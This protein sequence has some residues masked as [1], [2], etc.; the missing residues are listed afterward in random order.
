MKFPRT[1]IE[2]Q[3][4]F[5]SEASCWE[6]LREVRWPGGFRCPRCDCRG[7]SLISTRGLEQ[8]R[9]CRYQASV[10]AGTVFHKTRTP[11]RIWFL[12]VFFVAR[13]KKGI[14]AL[15]FQKDAGIGSYQ[16]AWTMLHKLRSAL[17]RRAGELLSGLV[18][19]DEAY[20][21]GPRPG[22]RGR[23]AANKSIVAV[24]VE[25]RAHSAG[26][27]HLDVIPDVSFDSLGPFV[28]GAIEGRNA[29]VLTDDWHG[30]WPLA[31]N[32]VDHVS[33]KLGSGPRA[34]E[35][36]PWVHKVI[37][38]LKTWLRGTFHGVSHKHLA[39]YLGE[40]RYRL[41][42]RWHEE[43]L[44]PAVLLRAVQGEPLPY[45]R[46]TAELVG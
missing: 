20:V 45:H 15:Q 14:S 37:S 38:N 22:S 11:L 43:D 41:N 9:S 8:C 39:R 31:R 27:A 13:H 18:E 21:G 7:S 42:G 23:H 46:L 16:T 6:Y 24:A 44:F 19:A 2:F 32:G 1:L 29:T 30:Y 4:Q 26:T 10:T 34:G 17:G 40:Y 33:T 5:P 36:L 28:R 25:R 12:A 3:D 35:V